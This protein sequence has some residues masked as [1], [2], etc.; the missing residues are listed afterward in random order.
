MNMRSGKLARN[1]YDLHGGG[2]SLFGPYLPLPAGQYTATVH[3]Y[4]F[5]QTASGATAEI[6]ST[7]RGSIA[8]APLKASEFATETTAISFTVPENERGFYE[9]RISAERGLGYRITGIFLERS[10]ATN[11]LATINDGKCY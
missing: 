7:A 5:N 8:N 3:T 10:K 2:I 9:I 1:V 6:Y 4:R 11:E